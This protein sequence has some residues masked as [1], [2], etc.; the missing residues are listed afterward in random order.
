MSGEAQPILTDL[1]KAQLPFIPGLDDDPSYQKW[2]DDT[3]RQLGIKTEGPPEF[4]GHSAEVWAEFLP[5]ALGKAIQEAEDRK[6]GIVM[7]EAMP[8]PRSFDRVKA[9]EDEL[10]MRRAKPARVVVESSR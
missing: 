3:K 4:K 1:A 10:R 5:P 6:R 9:A 2:R 8:D 7:G